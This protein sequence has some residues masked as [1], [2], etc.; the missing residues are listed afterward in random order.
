[1]TKKPLLITCA[2]SGVVLLSGT[3]SM[4]A[5]PILEERTTHMQNPLDVARDDLQRQKIQALQRSLH[6][7]LST[8]AAGKHPTRDFTQNDKRIFLVWQDQAGAK[9][10]RVRVDWV[11]EAVAGLPKDRALSEETQ[12]L[13]D[14]GSFKS[15]FFL[16]P[17]KATLPLG[18]YRADLYKN[19][20]LVR[21]LK[22]T[23]R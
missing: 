17:A 9:G 22:F 6:A 15:S 4:L 21:I 8:D 10:D 14:A 16:S 13:S 12:T 18:T 1:M 20:T 23:V 11:A 5:P 19:T 2:L 3:P 7:V